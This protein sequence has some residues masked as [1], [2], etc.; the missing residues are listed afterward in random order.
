MAG[1]KMRILLGLL[2]LLGWSSVLVGYGGEMR[3][4]QILKL[5]ESGDQ[6]LFLPFESKSAVRVDLKNKTVEHVTLP[7]S[8]RDANLYWLGNTL[9]ASTVAAKPDGKNSGTSSD[10]KV[11]KTMVYGVDY[12]FD[13]A[14]RKWVEFPIPTST[15]AEPVRGVWDGKPVLFAGSTE[16]TN[17][18]AL[19][20]KKLIRT[21]T[22]H[23]RSVG[24]GCYFRFTRDYGVINQLD[25][26]D[27]QGQVINNRLPKEKLV[28]RYGPVILR[29]GRDGKVRPQQDTIPAKISAGHEQLLATS[30]I[31]GNGLR[32]L[33]GPIQSYY[34]FKVWDIAS[35]QMKYSL[36]DDWGEIIQNKTMIIDFKRYLVTEPVW[37]PDG[38]Y[39]IVALEKRT[40]L[41]VGDQADA[42]T[43]IE[44]VLYRWDEKGGREIK[45]L[46]LG[47]DAC[48]SLSAT[49]NKKQMI[50]YTADPEPR[51]IM[52]PLKPEIDTAEISSLE[53]K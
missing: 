44:Y 26:V 9:H 24:D 23:V 27:N 12:E 29:T 3:S 18:Y 7:V 48:G 28:G 37:G 21:E 8:R 6:V 32:S 36:P 25:L 30:N 53:I 5:N 10:T 35:G 52:I 31:W 1:I 47:K 2:G 45:K 50:V 15:L 33:P 40:Y 39:G 42:L 41:R 46:E 43:A 20:T 13:E 17:I 4:P 14:N 11:K 38:I 22:N 19:D 16:L 34:R 51:L 49:A